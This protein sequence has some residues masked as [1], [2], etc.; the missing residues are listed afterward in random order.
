MDDIEP[1]R[2]NKQ[3]FGGGD[4][5][6]EIG[7]VTLEQQKKRISSPGGREVILEYEELAAKKNPTK[8]SFNMRARGPL[9]KEHEKVNS[10]AKGY[11]NI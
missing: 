5:T 9:Q 1:D 3:T 6:Q 2:C 8:N 10:K 4:K 7:R 11:Q